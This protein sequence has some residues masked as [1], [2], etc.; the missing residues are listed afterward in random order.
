MTTLY[1]PPVPLLGFAA[2]SGT[3][4]TTLLT[5][6]LPILRRRGLR[7][8]MIKHAHHAFD[9][10]KPGKDSYELRKAGA[11]QMLIAS[12]RRSALITENESELEPELASLL[13]QLNYDNLDLV[14][15]E[16]FKH[17]HFPKVEL[18]RKS[19]RHPLLFLQDPS[20]IALACDEA[21]EPSAALPVLDINQPDQVADFVCDYVAGAQTGA[22]RPER[23]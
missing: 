20:V 5:Q 11:A 19:L 22:P 21:I 23:S 7:V 6:L 8:A 3:G 1:T 16:G 12:S 14:L 13:Q 18:H 15:V 4:K 17:E 9:V 10:D 2:F